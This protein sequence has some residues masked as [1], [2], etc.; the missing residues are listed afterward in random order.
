MVLRSLAYRFTTQFP[1]VSCAKKHEKSELEK[2]AAFGLGRYGNSWAS[3]IYNPAR[4]RLWFLDRPR[5][6]VEVA[7]RGGN[8]QKATGGFRV[9]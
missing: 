7:K 1:V 5:M 3:N 4:Q 6:G 8:A 9:F 2:M